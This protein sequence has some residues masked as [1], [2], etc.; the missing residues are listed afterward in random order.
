MTQA[1]EELKLKLAE[2]PLEDRADLAQ[3]LIGSLDEAEEAGVEAAWEAELERRSAEIKSGT[4]AYEPADQ[5]FA[6]L[7]EKY[8]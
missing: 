7:R 5:V 6:R 2:L 4:A 1:A 3:Y 8:S